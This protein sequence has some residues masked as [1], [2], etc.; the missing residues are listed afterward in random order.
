MSNRVSVFT[1]SE[2]ITSLSSAVKSHNGMV[3]TEP[4]S[5]VFRL[6][7]R[8][9]AEVM[10]LAHEDFMSFLLSVAKYSDADIAELVSRGA[11]PEQIEDNE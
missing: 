9:V 11:L 2:M 3:D 8:P 7:L 1:V 4:T 10:Q 5:G 6:V